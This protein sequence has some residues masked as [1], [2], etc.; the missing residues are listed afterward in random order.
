MPQKNS[1]GKGLGA[2]FPDLLEGFN[3]RPSFVMCSIEELSPN[4]FQARRDFND[5][6]QQQLVSSI[7]ISGIIQ[8]IIVRKAAAGYEIIAGER[9]WRAAQQ[10]GLQSVPVIIREAQDLEVAELSL[11]EN[12][13]REAL[14]P[15][16]EAEAYQ[17]LTG[18]F[19]LSQEDLSTRV[20]KD[21]STIANTLRLLKLPPAVKNALTEKKITSG[22]ARSLLGIDSP[23][24]QLKI[25]ETVLKKALSVRDT[26]RLMQ[27]LKKTTPGKKHLKKDI[28]IMDV[29]RTLSRIMMAK[30]QIYLT[31][32]KSGRIE[33]IFNS[34][35]DLNRVIKL[36]MDE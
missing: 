17:T 35:D 31:K 13:Q 27:N 11:I 10:A 16:E 8:P 21:R 36:L 9:R 33:I 4:R 26:E 2:M 25:L 23:K 19:G 5:K 29:E 34:A 12:I 18:H 7:K 30:V 3:N 22:H 6:Q 20:G 24:E 28:Y 14:N 1:L 32:K 15:I